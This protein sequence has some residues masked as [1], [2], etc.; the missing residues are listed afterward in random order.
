MIRIIIYPSDVQLL[1]NKSET[2]ARRAIQNLKKSLNREKH[3]V[4]TIKE[5]CHYFGYNVDEVI[6]T[7]SKY[8]LN[9]AS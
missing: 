3:Q 2:Y 5:F 6:A 9:K 7:L 4:V 1:T 8:E